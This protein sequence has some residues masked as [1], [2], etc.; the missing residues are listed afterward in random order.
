MR[1][2]MT[3]PT[4]LATGSM[5]H[6]LGR[7]EDTASGACRH[8]PRQGLRRSVRFYVEKVSSVRRERCVGAS[9]GMGT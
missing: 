5:S 9:A 8:I 1:C 4:A 3:P 2:R 6:D 7:A